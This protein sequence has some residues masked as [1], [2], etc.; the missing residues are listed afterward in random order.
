MVP[1]SADGQNKTLICN[2]KVNGKFQL[3]KMWEA[4]LIK[5]SF[6]E[7]VTPK[8]RGGSIGR[9]DN[10]RVLQGEGLLCKGT[11]IGRMRMVKG[12]GSQHGGAQG[13]GSLGRRQ[14]VAERTRAATC[15]D[16]ERDGIRVEKGK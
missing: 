10:G 4:D 5:D 1:L 15:R 3:L 14:E 11:V 6:L 9:G 7:E 8:L 13:T 12:T 16:D 2:H